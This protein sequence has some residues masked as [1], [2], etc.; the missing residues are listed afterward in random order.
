MVR[1]CARILVC[2]GFIATTIDVRAAIDIANGVGT[3]EWPAVGTLLKHEGNS[4]FSCT[5]T[6]ISP[7]WVLTA[8]HCVVDSPVPP[9]PADFSFV[10]LTDYACCF[11]SGGL[12]VVAAVSNPGFMP[13]DPNPAHDQGLV[14]LAT[15]VTDVVPF[16]VNADLMPPGSGSFLEVLGYGLLENDSNTLKRRGLRS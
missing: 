4:I 2:A 3:S 5:A 15:P 12:S 11:V 16:T 1:H 10:M 13:L 9:N 6:L 14:Q 7:T 8:A